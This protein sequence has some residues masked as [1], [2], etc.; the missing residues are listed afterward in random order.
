MPAAADPCQFCKYDLSGV[1]S[2][3][4]RERTCP[5]CGR[6]NPPPPSGPLSTEHLKAIADARVR[7]KKIR[8]AANVAA[9][10]G[11]T[12][13]IFAVITLAG[14]LFGDLIALILGA[15]LAVITVNELRGAAKLRRF[16]PSGPILL[17]I[18]QLVLAAVIFFYGA[19][20]L[21]YTLRHPL[22]GGD[23]Q[24]ADLN[25]LGVDF[26]ELSRTLAFVLYGGVALFGLLGPGFTALYYYSRRRLVRKM[27]DET[28]EWVIAALRAAG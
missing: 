10:S 4:S 8:R 7:G 16:D 14:G 28:P 24:L 5:E 12:M 3:A 11:W 23:A 20:M 13:A 22:L 26:S 1:A 17:A 25:Q 19:Y 2:A 9:F 6:V 21:G 27:H 18:N 15:L